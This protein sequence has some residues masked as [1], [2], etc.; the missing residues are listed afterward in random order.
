MRFKA[1]ADVT[2]PLICGR[3]HF[4][5][6]SRKQAMSHKQKAQDFSRAFA[7]LQLQG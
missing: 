6:I 5:S 4:S 7:F 3:F 2:A 1:T